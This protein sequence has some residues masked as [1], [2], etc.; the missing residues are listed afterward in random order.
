MTQGIS[1]ET[2]AAAHNNR[3][4]NYM[5]LGDV[6]KALEDFSNAIAYDEDWGQAYLNRA[7]IYAARNEFALAEADLNQAVRL[8]PA[9]IRGE[10]FLLR[11]TMRAIGNDRDGALADI[12]EAT[13][14]ARRDAYANNEIA[15]FLATFPD[16]TY[17]NGEEAIRL[18]QRAVDREED[19]YAFRDTLAAAYAAA[20]MFEA[21][22]REESLA[23]ELANAEGVDTTSFSD[24]LAIYQSGSPFPT[25]ARPQF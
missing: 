3:G 25:G 6:D 11:A 24:R 9:R 13:D 7:R 10:A 21:A 8:R 14:R 16:P 1:A 12:A 4:A 19:S 18:A 2:R 22:V 20:G 15:W 23:I 5:A 17:R